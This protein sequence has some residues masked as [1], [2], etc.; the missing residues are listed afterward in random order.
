MT[1]S[2][3]LAVAAALSAIF[4]LSN[5]ANAQT[6]PTTPA[7]RANP[8]APITATESGNL[9]ELPNGLTCRT[10]TPKGSNCICNGH[11]GTVK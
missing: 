2:H 11:P 4:S 6:S 10:T 7:P 1:R 3:A 5:F 9:C 8:T